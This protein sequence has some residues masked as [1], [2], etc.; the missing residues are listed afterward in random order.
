MSRMVKTSVFAALLGTASAGAAT[1]S[2]FCS[3]E[4]VSNGNMNNDPTSGSDQVLSCSQACMI[5]A[6]GSTEADCG[7]NCDRNGASGCSLTVNDYT[8]SMCQAR[9]D[10]S[11]AALSKMMSQASCKEGCAM[12]P[13]RSCSFLQPAMRQ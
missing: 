8:Y 13:P 2:A 5:R 3:Q 6:R 12:T 7:S 11:S 10:Y 4:C 9:Q 1:I